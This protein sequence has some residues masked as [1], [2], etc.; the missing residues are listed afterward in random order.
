MLQEFIKIKEQQEKDSI[1]SSFSKIDRIQLPPLKYVIDMELFREYG[2]A[3]NYA[4]KYNFNFSRIEIISK[5]D[6]IEA[7]VGKR[8]EGKS[9]NL[10]FEPFEFGYFC[11][12]CGHY[13]DLDN[14][15]EIELMHL[16]FSEYRYF[17]YCKRCNI[18]IPSYACLDP[19]SKDNV[20]EI[21]DTYLSMLYE[22][23]KRKQFEIGK[24]LRKFL[25]NIKDNKLKKKEILE[26]LERFTNALPKQ[27]PEYK[28]RI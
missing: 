8:Y 24:L 13:P 1:W 7:V 28:H 3:I 14:D 23:G 27:D 11:P 5:D 2:R 19:Q 18:D 10:L 6:N 4:I 12:L 16:E 26:R 22:T 15:G 20:K 25:I 17:M 9:M 21:T